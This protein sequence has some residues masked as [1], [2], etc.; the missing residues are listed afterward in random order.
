MLGYISLSILRVWCR[1]ILADASFLT[2]IFDIIH[3]VL[4]AFSVSIT[5]T[6]S[7]AVLFAYS[8][9]MIIFAWSTKR[10]NISLNARAAVGVLN[11][12]VTN[13][14]KVFINRN[15]TSVGIIVQVQR[16]GK[17]HHTLTVFITF[18]YIFY[19]WLNICVS[20]SILQWGN[21]E[22]HDF[23]VLL[24]ANRQKLWFIHT[25]VYA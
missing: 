1:K 6:T 9:N 19:Q 20:I 13:I 15:Y 4:S 8:Y 24:R 23:Y 16:A 10:G 17:S 18:D 3:H 12:V 14:C 2:M 25:L 22:K 11:S 7:T 5:I 21:G